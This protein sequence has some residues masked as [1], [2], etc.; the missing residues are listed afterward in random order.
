MKEKQSKIK[1]HKIIVEQQRK[2][3]KEK[4]NTGE[5]GNYSKLKRKSWQKER[6]KVLEEKRLALGNQKIRNEDRKY[7]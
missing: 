3:A 2:A 7:S 4:W 1:L 5:R 6:K